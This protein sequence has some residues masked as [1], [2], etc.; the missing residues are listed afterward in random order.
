MNYFAGKENFEKLS[1]STSSIKNLLLDEDIDPNTNLFNEKKFQKLD[2]VYCTSDEL[3]SFGKNF[4]P[5]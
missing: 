2:F 4:F 3:L 1:F 5:R